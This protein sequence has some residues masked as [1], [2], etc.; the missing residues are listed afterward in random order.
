M[1]VTALISA[2]YAGGLVE[3]VITAPD[4]DDALYQAQ[5]FFDDE[6]MSDAEEIRIDIVAAA[7]SGDDMRLRRSRP[8]HIEE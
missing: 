4:I 8:F 2:V 5:K 6:I 1:A 7:R 3:E